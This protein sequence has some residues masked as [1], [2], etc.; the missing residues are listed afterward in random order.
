MEDQ[1]N[2]P[3]RKWADPSAGCDFRFGEK[4]LRILWLLMRLLATLVMPKILVT[5]D[6]DVIQSLLI[7]TVLP[8]L[9]MVIFT[10]SLRMRRIG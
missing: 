6:L 10:D 5:R 4:E 3:K 7:N 2:T 9:S 8:I 1:I